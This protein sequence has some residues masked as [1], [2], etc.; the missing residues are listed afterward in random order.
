[1]INRNDAVNR[2]S[3]CVQPKCQMFRSIGTQDSHISSSYTVLREKTFAL[4]FKGIPSTSCSLRTRAQF[5]T[6]LRCC[7]RLCH[8]SSCCHCKF[9]RSR[10]VFDTSVTASTGIH[11]SGV[12]AAAASTILG[13]PSACAGR[14]PC[15][16][17]CCLR[18]KIGRC[19]S[20]GVGATTRPFPFFLSSAD[21]SV[22][23]GTA[24][25]LGATA[26]AACCAAETDV[27]NAATAAATA[28]ATRIAACCTAA[29]TVIARCAAAA[30][31]VPTAVPITSVNAVD[32]G[33]HCWW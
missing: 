13:L 14:C 1:M 31:I 4:I 30:D 21:G 29:I 7:V 24:A 18:L 23:T 15:C 5:C 10:C 8:Y 6:T 33:V 22:G 3:S 20:A 17:P 32:A 28:A 16:F 12:T 26:F 11:H 9:V 2:S 19:G 27:V 25:G